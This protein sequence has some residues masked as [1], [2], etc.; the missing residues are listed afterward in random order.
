MDISIHRVTRVELVT[1]FSSNGNSRT[2]RIVTKDPET[3]HELTVFG[4][5][6]S[7]MDVLPMAEDFRDH[8][9][10]RESIG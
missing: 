7:A 5:G 2:V 6:A 3:S 1:R 9:A 8:D 10:K 4:D